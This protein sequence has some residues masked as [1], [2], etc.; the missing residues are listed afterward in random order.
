[1]SSWDALVI[2]NVLDEI[3]PKLNANEVTTKWLLQIL[4]HKHGWDSEVLKTHKK[5][6]RAMAI[7]RINQIEQ[8][9]PMEEESTKPSKKT[10]MEKN[11]PLP[12]LKLKEMCRVVG[13]LSPHIFRQ[14]KTD[15]SIDDHKAKEAFLRNKL[16]DAGYPIR[17]SY[18]NREEIHLARKKRERERDLDGMDASLI[19][20]SR[21]R[22]NNNSDSIPVNLSSATVSS[23]EE[24]EA[25]HSDESEDEAEF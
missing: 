17:G 13:L 11:E 18:P 6:V 3:I 14:L 2:G 21:R 15:F 24:E 7:A 16:S 5:E 12:L 9:Q 4:E 23:E 10:N 8:M 19:L 1:M 25:S 20:T 22:R